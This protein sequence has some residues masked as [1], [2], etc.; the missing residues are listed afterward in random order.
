[1][2]SA[3]RAAL[4]VRTWFLSSR[5]V[6]FPGRHTGQENSRIA[7]LRRLDRGFALRNALSFCRQQSLHAVACVGFSWDAVA[8]RSDRVDVGGDARVRNFAPSGCRTYKIGAGQSIPGEPAAKR[9]T[10]PG[11]G[12]GREHPASAV[13]V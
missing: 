12:H 10:C 1:M 5:R 3:P 13:W 7:V 4:I 11:S 2:R 8:L 9:T 6:P